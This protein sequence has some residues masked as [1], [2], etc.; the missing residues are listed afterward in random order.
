MFRL[1]FLL[2]NGCELDMLGEEIEFKYVE[3]LGGGVLSIL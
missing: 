2:S 1:A 3:R